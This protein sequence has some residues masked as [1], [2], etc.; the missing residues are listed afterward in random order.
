MTELALFKMGKIRRLFGE[1][2]QILVGGTGGDFFFYSFVLS[3]FFFFS[4]VCGLEGEEG[5]CTFKTSPCVPAPR[6]HVEKHVDVVPVHT[7]TF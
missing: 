7:G 6:A 1:P 4:R 5:V 2:W 3:F